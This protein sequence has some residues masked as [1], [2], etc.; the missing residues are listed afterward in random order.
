MFWKKKKNIDLGLPDESSDHRKAF[1]VKPDDTRPV[2]LSLAGNSYHVTSISGTGCC[3]R[4][5]NYPD[6]FKATAT[7]RIP[8][9]DV[10]FPVSIRV[11]SRKRDLCRCEF[12]K[13]PEK[14]ADIIHAYVLQVQKN[15]IRNK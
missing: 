10:I 13:I 4:S 14:S 1:R 2:I 9:E 3:F 8:S 12:S 6:G 11:V 5:H 7:L 15:S